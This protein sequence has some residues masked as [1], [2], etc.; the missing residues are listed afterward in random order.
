[1]AFVGIDSVVFGAPDVRRACKLFSDWGLTKLRGGRAGAVLETAIGSQVVVRPENS[2]RLPPKMSGGSNFREIV[3]GIS[4]R[5][6][7]DAIAG[8]LARDREVRADQDGTLRAVDDCGI[9]IGFR[10]WTHRTERPGRG[11][12]FN[13][14]GHRQRVDAAANAYERAHPQRMGHLAFFV[15]DVRTGERFYRRL[16]FWLSDRYAGG[17]AV[18]LRH[19]A[20]S[21][22][23]NLFFESRVISQRGGNDNPP[24]LVD[25]AFRGG[26]N[27]NSLER[28]D[29][30]FEL[31]KRGHFILNC[32]PLGHRIGPKTSVKIGDDETFIV[33]GCENFPK[34]GRD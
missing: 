3:W 7:L 6:H 33:I 26:R 10:V 2:P 18:F 14:P 24:L 15:P 8:E 20:Q 27:K 16:G 13:S 32:L 4:S 29:L 11:T 5:K 1:M 25:R 21:D 30:I 22:H 12:P 9:N 28:F 34:F 17:A 31:G 19:A 23:H